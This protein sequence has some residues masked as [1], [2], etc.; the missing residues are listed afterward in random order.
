[1]SRVRFMKAAT[2]EELHLPL[3]ICTRVRTDMPAPTL[4]WWLRDIASLLE[5]PI[6]AIRFVA[7]TVD[8]DSKVISD[9]CPVYK[10]TLLNCLQQDADGNIWVQVL[11]DN[12]NLLREEVRPSGFEKRDRE[13]GAK[14][15]ET[16]PEWC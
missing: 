12:L 10:R 8:G 2:G 3:R 11:V 4:E 9:G 7:T 1:M 6:S 13:E 5:K 16:F 14:T 15:T